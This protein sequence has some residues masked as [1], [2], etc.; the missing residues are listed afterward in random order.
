MPSPI[1]LAAPVI[2]AVLPSTSYI[3]AILET[4]QLPGTDDSVT[5][6]V[7]ARRCRIEKRSCDEMQHVHLEVNQVRERRT[8]DA[9]G[10]VGT[11]D[12]GLR[13]HREALAPGSTTA[14]RCLVSCRLFWCNLRWVD[15]PAGHLQCHTVVVEL[16]D[17]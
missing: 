1:P 13:P 9:F 15:K 10:L 16:E 2:T 4:G 8:D 11:G 5:K 14:L 3:R 12:V 7:L 6:Q 17:A